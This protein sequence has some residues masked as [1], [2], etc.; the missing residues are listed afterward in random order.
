MKS[1]K[2]FTDRIWKRIYRDVWTCKCDT[3]KDV[4]ENW[5]IIIDEFHAKCLHMY[6]EIHEYKDKK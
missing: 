3:C 4:A 2:F 1:L 5:L 6:Q